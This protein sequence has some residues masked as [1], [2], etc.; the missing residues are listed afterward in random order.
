MICIRKT[1]IDG[2][3]NEEN[4]RIGVPRLGVIGCAV[5]RKSSAWTKFHKETHAGRTTRAYP[6]CDDTVLCINNPGPTTI[7]PKNNIIRCRIIATLEEVEEE[8]SSLDIDVARVS[9]S[10]V[11]SFN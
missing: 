11:V 6:T 3:I 2:L 10:R 7:G 9:A 4:V 1:N 5:S 8:V